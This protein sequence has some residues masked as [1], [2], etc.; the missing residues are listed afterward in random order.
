ML[1]VRGRPDGRR[2]PRPVATRG[3]TVCRATRRLRREAQSLPLIDDRISAIIAQERSS[4]SRDGQSPRSL[5]EVVASASTNSAWLPST[6]VG[7]PSRSRAQGPDWKIPLPSSATLG[8]ARR[9]RRVRSRRASRTRLAPVPGKDHVSDC[10][11]HARSHR[12]SASHD[13]NLLASE[14]VDGQVAGLI[15]STRPRPQI[16]E[17]SYMRSSSPTR[18]SYQAGTFSMNS[19]TTTARVSAPGR[20]SL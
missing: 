9:G 1:G 8:R 19:A 14:S 15:H 11:S 12:G 13:V 4:Q 5:L 10:C 17:P 16:L 20:M 2:S 6:R 18:T 3:Q 7:L